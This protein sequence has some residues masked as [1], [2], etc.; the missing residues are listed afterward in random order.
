MFSLFLA[1]SYCFRT[2]IGRNLNSLQ[3]HYI[4]RDSLDVSPNWYFI[5]FE[6][7]PNFTM[8]H[9]YKIPVLFNNFVSNNI[10]RIFCSKQNLS[11]IKN[12][13]NVEIYPVLPSMKYIG[14][15]IN[16]NQITKFYFEADSSF[17]QTL[18]SGINITK[19]T[20]TSYIATTNNGENCVNI[21]SHSN[22]VISIFPFAKK[23][24]QNRYSVGRIQGGSEPTY[25]SKVF[26]SQRYMADHGLTG[27]NQVI[28]VSD[29][30][31]DMNSTYFY[32][33][34]ESISFDRLNKDHH[35]ILYYSTKYGDNMDSSGHGTIVNGIATG[36]AE[37]TDCVDAL[38]NGVAPDAKIAFFDL[39]ESEEGFVNDL[40]SEH[41]KEILDLTGAKVSSASLG[42][43]IMV[44]DEPIEIINNNYANQLALEKNDTL[45]LY[46]AGNDGI[47]MRTINAPATAK[48]VL[49][50]GNIESKWAESYE[51]HH[52]TIH[53]DVQIEDSKGNKVEGFIPEF[54]QNLAVT[55]EMKIEGNL[56]E[57]ENAKE[58]DIANIRASN[59]V[60]SAL[61]SSK[62]RAAVIYN[63]SLECSNIG[64]PV[65]VLGNETVIV[66]GAIKITG[67]TKMGIPYQIHYTSSRGPTTMGLKKP[68]VS[69]IGTYVVSA[70][71]M[72]GEGKSGHNERI[73]VSGTSLSTPMVAGAAILIREYFEKGMFNGAQF[74]PNANT[75]KA[76]LAASCDPVEVPVGVRAITEGHGEVNLRN[77]LNVENQNHLRM[78]IAQNIE[79]KSGQHLSASIK[80][81][82][83]G[84]PIRI[85]IAYNDPVGSTDSSMNIIVDVSMYVE[86]PKINKF[87]NDEEEM[88]SAIEAVIF[89]GEESMEGE[90]RIHL[91]A[92]GVEAAG[93][94]FASVVVIGDLESDCFIDFKEDEKCIGNNANC[95]KGISQCDNHHTGLA[96]QLPI[97]ELAKGKS[98]YNLSPLEIKHFSI[99]SASD[100]VIDVTINQNE[101][102]MSSDSFA[103]FG[104]NKP[105]TLSDHSKTVVFSFKGDDDMFSI[106]AKRGNTY[107]ISVY[108]ANS[109]PQT[110]TFDIDQTT[111]K[112]IWIIV[113]V[114][115][116]VL[117]LV[118]AISIYFC[119][120]RKRK[121]AFEDS[122]LQQPIV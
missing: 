2:A 84:N 29:T 109:F 23:R 66:N 91:V 96:C 36:N 21:L 78:G 56:V 67:L 85:A 26:E 43:Q 18:Y 92:S 20:D 70:K 31:I 63:N 48:N 87:G 111:W 95:V 28:A 72:R 45:F 50:I 46:A 14:N 42:N 5:E 98:S 34:G 113:G 57:Y 19:L 30:G 39:E 69:A 25:D 7:S 88:Q 103:Y 86:G 59:D 15:K 55:K 54:A 104:S 105:K 41:H 53:P 47:E 101:T 61:N 12:N 4:G 102:I 90:Y 3:T 82:K 118:I 62:F 64:Y 71:S 112:E 116:A 114:A 6:N 24:I 17:D 8:F 22:S 52:F 37:C 107:Y 11:F 100:S 27:K 81:N 120:C 77:I 110:Y 10:Y 79:I 89:R 115:A 44:G 49:G 83:P 1:N 119:C 73:I 60:C 9:Q 108:N 38:Y 74:D 80:I 106:N 16:L 99:K 58:T 32:R 33:E 40:P 65:V 93:S 68:D 13:F 35:K 76:L 121:N 51:Y 117:V 94:V 97:T 75:L 122:S